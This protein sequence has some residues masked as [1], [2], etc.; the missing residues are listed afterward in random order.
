MFALSRHSQSQEIGLQLS[1]KSIALVSTSGPA[2]YSFGSWLRRFGVGLRHFWCAVN[3]LICH[4]M[5]QRSSVGNEAFGRL[6]RDRLPLLVM[7]NIALCAAHA[8][9]KSGLSNTQFFAD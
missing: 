8:S 2:C 4:D 3:I 7:P 5:P 9:G 6:W 1:I